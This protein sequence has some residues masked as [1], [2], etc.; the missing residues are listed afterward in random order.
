VL[1]RNYQNLGK[2]SRGSGNV[3]L[4]DE[5]L[6]NPLEVFNADIEF[7]K[8]ILQID[9]QLYLKP[10]FEVVDGFTAFKKPESA[11]LA[12]IL[13]ISFWISFLMGYLIIGAWRLDKKL[14]SYQ[15]TE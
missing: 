1:F 14:A 15:T 11:S 7:N 4:G 12:K 8:E 9:R 6:A 2:T 10:D 3:F 5:K 13:F